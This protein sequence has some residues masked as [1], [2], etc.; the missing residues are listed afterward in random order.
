MN[1]EICIL[2]GGLSTRL[3]RDK[4][5]FRFGRRTM[6]SIIRGEAKELNYPVRVIRRDLVPRCGPLGGIFT[7]LKTTRAEAVLFLACDMPLISEEL[8]KHLVTASGTKMLPVIVAQDNRVGFPFILPRSAL[9]DV[10]LRLAQK[11]FSI[12]ALAADVKAGKLR[13]P[14][15]S[16]ELFNV[17]TVADAQRAAALLADRY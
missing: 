5:R 3:G 17:N 7:A 15:R 1:L 9:A 2:A 14:K 11:Q 6:L 12:H 10:E 8:L 16:H 13:V 4:A